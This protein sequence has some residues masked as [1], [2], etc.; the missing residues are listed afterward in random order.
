MGAAR[1]DG[2]EE[3]LRERGLRA[4]PQRRLV[5]DALQALGHGTP[6]QVVERVQDVA[7]SLSLSTVYRTLELLEELGLVSHT[8][9]NHGSASYS[10]A[11]HDDHIHLVCRRCGRVEEAEVGRVRLL[12][13]EVNARHGFVADV[14]HLSLHGLCADCAAQREAER[15][16]QR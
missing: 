2:L 6:D 1:S 13:D 12:A 3:A 9:L 15:P 5:L 7:P 14:A 4:T 16:A 11:T 10:L 8:H